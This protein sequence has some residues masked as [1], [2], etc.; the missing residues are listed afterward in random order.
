MMHAKRLSAGLG[1]YQTHS[2]M[3]RIS[4]C[5]TDGMPPTNGL[6]VREEVDESG[7]FSAKPVGEKLQFWRKNG[8]AFASFCAS[9]LNRACSNW[10]RTLIAEIMGE[11]ELAGKRRSINC[12]LESQKFDTSRSLVQ[13]SRVD[14]SR[15][16]V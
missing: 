10:T 9:P 16:L 8:C 7:F 3:S 15:S 13:C 14:L 5:P 6:K 12:R 11:K 1:F 4:G 2:R